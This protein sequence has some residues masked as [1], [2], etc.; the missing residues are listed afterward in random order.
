MRVEDDDQPTPRVLRALA[1]AELGMATTL[2]P[3]LDRDGLGVL[4]RWL[5]AP[6]TVQALAGTGAAISRAQ[7]LDEVSR[8]L[9]GERSD[10]L[11]YFAHA[12][13]LLDDAPDDLTGLET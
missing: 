3:H 4:R 9:A 6:D 5:R 10:S 11:A 1:C 8:R 2:S 13:D 7:L 12:G